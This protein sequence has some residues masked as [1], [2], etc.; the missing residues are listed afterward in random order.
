M[1][2]GRGNS[3]GP[4]AGFI[5]RRLD[6]PCASLLQNVGNDMEDNAKKYSILAVFIQIQ[7]QNIRSSF[8]QAFS[9]KLLMTFRSVLWV[10][11]VCLRNVHEG[12]IGSRVC[13]KNA[14][15]E[16]RIQG[17]ACSICSSKEQAAS[18]SK[19]CAKLPPA[20]VGGADS[21]TWSQLEKVPSIVTVRMCL[22]KI[23]YTF[24]KACTS[25]EANKHSLPV[26]Y[27]RI[28]GFHKS[29]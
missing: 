14:T 5:L 3:V 13:H 16:V 23:V 17:S 24:K 9:F 10:W 20:M 26:R 7:W 27:G 21:V 1:Q 4:E 12:G 8:K 11:I 19:W 6:Q 28:T 18:H 2:Q 25:W 15:P 22:I 29:P